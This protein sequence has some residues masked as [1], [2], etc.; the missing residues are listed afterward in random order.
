[1]DRIPVSS[2]NLRDVGY[3]PTGRVLEVGFKDGSVYQYF[4]VPAS[5]AEGLL[6]ASSKGGYLARNVK[7]RYRYVRL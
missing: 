4:E 7:G 1:M 3:D 6:S 5:V 2:S